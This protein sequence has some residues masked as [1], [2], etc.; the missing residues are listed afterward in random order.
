MVVDLMDY[1]KWILYFS[2]LFLVAGCASSDCYKESYLFNGNEFAIGYQSKI[3]GLNVAEHSRLMKKIGEE[4]FDTKEE[5]IDAGFKVISCNT[6][7][8]N[9]SYCSGVKGIK[10]IRVREICSRIGSIC[11]D[12]TYSSSRGR[13]TCSHHGGIA[14]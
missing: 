4:I 2:L 9:V 3:T 11:E 1:F 12:G 6:T 7:P 5:M 8:H 14:Y 13:G 10:E